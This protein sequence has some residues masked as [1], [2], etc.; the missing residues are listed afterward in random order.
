MGGPRHNASSRGRWLQ[1]LFVA[2]L[3]L[4]LWQLIAWAL[5]NPLLF[6]GPIEVVGA[7]GERAVQQTFWVSIGWSFL[8]IALG[9]LVAVAAGVVLGLLAA[10]FRWMAAL[11]A[12]PLFI[13]KS[14]PVVCFIALLL[15]LLGSHGATSMV[16][17]MVVFPPI[18]AAMIEGAAAQ[19]RALD[20]MAAVFGLSPLRRFL[21]VE[22]PRYEPFLRAAF[23]SAVGMSW[24]AG[25][26]AELIGLPG[27][28]IG[29]GVYLAKL[30]L[31]V[32]GIIAWTAVVIAVGW[33][34]EKG[35]LLA[36]DLLCALPD[37]H[38][39]DRV[40]RASALVA[41]KEGSMV[42]GAT[43]RGAEEADD[44]PVME[45]SAIV[46]RFGEKTVLDGFSLRLLPGERVCL[47]APSG[48]GKTTLLRLAAGLEQPDAGRVDVGESAVVFQEARLREDLTAAENLALT[49]RDEQELAYGL[50]LLA[51]LLPD[52]GDR[53]GKPVRSLSGGM[54][55]RLEVARALAHPASVLLLDEPFAGLDEAT[56]AT[57]AHTILVHQGSRPLL[58]TTHSLQDPTLLFAS[59]LYL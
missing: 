53:E 45:L 43:A 29:E 41:A 51:V 42:E 49:A 15:V 40:R 19:D 32:P 2:V 46:K 11:L 16:V 54:R 25:I 12:P 23:K 28:S 13:V 1:R 33:L 10:R 38:L 55:R 5:G 31:D 18:Y 52:E 26:A 48:T 39:T 37:R 17:A 20:E 27:A 24:K 22:L 6:C 36:F 59:S 8:R 9:F 30:S 58:L 3:W 4:A 50:R 56:K 35:V 21:H 7:L 14:A 44:A 57:V 34:C 47:M